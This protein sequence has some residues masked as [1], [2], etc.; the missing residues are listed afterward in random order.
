MTTATKQDN[1]ALYDQAVHWDRDR[2]GWFYEK[3][4]IFEALVDPGVK[5]ILDVGCGDGKITNSFCPDRKVVAC[6]RS[7]TALQHVTR[8]KVLASCDAL[9]F[10]D[11][12]FDLV[13][14]SE[15]LEHLPD[16]TYLQ[17]VA[18][19]AR[20]ARRHILISVP[21]RET[22]AQGLARCA[23]CG[24]RYHA[25]GQV[26]SFRKPADLARRFPGFGLTFV[27]FCGESD[28]RPPSWM[29]RVRRLLL[30]DWPAH[31]RAICPVCGSKAVARNKKKYPRM[32]WIL[33]RV[34]WRL[35]SRPMNY[36]MVVRL[37][38]TRQ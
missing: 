19:L 18:E 22:L 30:A 11:R 38:R 16:R 9:P 20:V 28:G 6:D 36:W 3:T 34:Q 21:Y 35:L 7:Q 29:L 17:A 1:P 26:R 33:D 31:E 12:S 8:P 25:D 15:V 2:D 14:C 23:S 27:G 37:E 10:G 24:A 13:L 4:R 32:Q 5:T